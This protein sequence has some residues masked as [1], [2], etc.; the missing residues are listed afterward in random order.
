M[1]PALSAPVGHRSI[2][3][4]VRAS[5]PPRA[6]KTNLFRHLHEPSHART[7]SD[8]A[9]KITSIPEVPSRERGATMSRGYVGGRSAQITT[10]AWLSSVK[11]GQPS[12]RD[13]SSGPTSGGESAAQSRFN[14]R[15]RPPSVVDPSLSFLEARA[16]S[17]S[18]DREK[19]EEERRE[20]DANHSLQDE[21][22][23]QHV[24]GEYWLTTS[25]ESCR[26]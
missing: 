21:Y 10:F 5:Q 19:G 16:K 17:G 4:E 7:L 3:A 11:V 24:L 15:S 1:P 14:S 18:R 12:T 6:P 13:S 2:L 9:G 20:N 25:A 26:S 22:V 8:V 23:F